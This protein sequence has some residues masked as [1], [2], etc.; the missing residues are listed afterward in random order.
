[1]VQVGTPSG[2]MKVNCIERL[3]MNQ[4]RDLELWKSIRGYPWHLRPGDVQNEPGEIP[5]MVASEPV[6]LQDELPPRLPKEREAESVLR[7][8]YI[9]RNVELRQYGFTQGC[10]GCTAAETGRAPENHSETCRQR[11]ESAMEADDVERSRVEVNRRAR[12]EAGA[13]RQPRAGGLED[14]PVSEVTTGDDD[15]V[16]AGGAEGNTAL[17]V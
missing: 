2:V 5:T 14:L 10:S 9:R 1:M 7:R 12:E 17:Q 6:V 3:P 4:A 16:N 15:D 11:V 13:A 8:V